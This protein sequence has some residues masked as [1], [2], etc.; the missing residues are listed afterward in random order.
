MKSEFKD[1]FVNAL[2]VSRPWHKKRFGVVPIPEAGL[3][4]FAAAFGI[5]VPE[6]FAA[7]V[8]AGNLGKLKELLT[9]KASYSALEA[10]EKWHWR[11]VVK[12]NEIDLCLTAEIV[13]RS[14]RN[15]PPATT[16]SPYDYFWANET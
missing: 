9:A 6:K 11:T 15:D 4:Y 13:G 8:V 1:R 14:Q 12:H 5:R 3:Q 16:F 2:R 7:G 10:S